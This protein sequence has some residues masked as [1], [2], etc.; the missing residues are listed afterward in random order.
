MATRPTMTV[1]FSWASDFLTNTNLAFIERA[2]ELATAR[3]HASA[4][5]HVEL[6]IDRDTAGVP[7][8]PDV[9]Q[10]IF[11][12]IAQADIFVADVSIVGTLP[13]L[14]PDGSPRPTPNPNVLIELGFAAAQ[15]TIGWDR[16]VPVFNRAT[17]RVEDLPFDIRQR[18]IVSY[19]LAP[20]PEPGKADPSKR[21]QRD[22]LVDALHQRLA[23][24]VAEVAPGGRKRKR[25]TAPELRAAWTAHDRSPS[26]LL[27]EPVRW[28]SLA[29]RHAEVRRLR[30]SDAD[31]AQIESAWPRIVEIVGQHG[32][33][34]LRPLKE[35][36]ALD[37]LRQEVAALAT[38]IDEYLA[39]T[40]TPLA[41]FGFTHE[42][43]RRRIKA[44]LSVVNEGTAPATG[45]SVLIEPSDRVRFITEK[46]QFEHGAL[47]PFRS[48][49]LTLLLK[50]ASDPDAWMEHVRFEKQ[51]RTTQSMLSAFDP[52]WIAPRPEHQ[53]LLLEL[54]R[55]NP[56]LRVD[57]GRLHATFKRPVQHRFSSSVDSNDVWILA[58]LEAGEETTLNYAC[59]AN[60]LPEP[61]CGTLT[62][63]ARTETANEM[64]PS[65]EDDDEEVDAP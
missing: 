62:V 18:R 55:D 10:T 21:P 59:H 49:A 64:P 17:G 61:D 41:A 20:N 13:A 40:P 5:M 56:D 34:F 2:L 63:R 4:D 43:R 7:G 50:V 57:H 53:R 29:A 48:E 47:R 51:L 30:V 23:A 58:A 11:D 24:M 26:T 6:R 3:L 54:G 12:K 8:A 33:D 31:L 9:A 42:V 16:I 32:L 46:T 39:A 14:K 38:R 37:D 15:P 60:E 65:G 28:P 27:V 22:T 35:V 45:V 44:A 19:E 36:P 1:F 52:A 25:G